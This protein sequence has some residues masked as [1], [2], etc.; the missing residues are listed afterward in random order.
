NTTQLC[1]VYNYYKNSSW[2]VPTTCPTS[3]QASPT[4]TTD[5]GSVWNY[6]DGD[7]Y[8]KGNCHSAA[9]SYDGVNRL[10][11][12]IGATGAPSCPSGTENYNFP[13]IYTADGSNG[14]Y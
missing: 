10:T 14:Q 13:Y 6:W 1:L 2:P 11:S 12:A 7:N 3:S 4:G 5:N 9:Y 8:V